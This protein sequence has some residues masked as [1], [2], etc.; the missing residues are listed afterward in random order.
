MMATLEH[1]I[2]IQL[3]AQDASREWASF[4]FHSLVG[5]FRTPGQRLHWRDEAGSEAWGVVLLV[6]LGRSHTRIHVAIDYFPVPLAVSPGDLDA[7]IAADLDSY[8]SFVE[9]NAECRETQEQGA[10]PG[11]EQRRTSTAT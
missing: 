3:S 5:F 6:S 8:R 9:S 11:D 10:A 1:V 2:D 4:P 7:Q